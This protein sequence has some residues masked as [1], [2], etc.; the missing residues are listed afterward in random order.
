MEAADASGFDLPQTANKIVSFENISAPDKYSAMTMAR[1]RLLWLHDI[2]GLFRHRSQIDM[3]N[4]VL[5]YSESNR[6]FTKLKSN[7]NH[8]HLI[9]DSR[10]EKANKRLN[11]MISDLRI[12]DGPDG[13]RFFRVIEFHGLSTRSFSNENQ[14]INLW[15]ALETITSSHDGSSSIVDSVTREALPILSLNYFHRIFKY[16]TFDI[17]RWNRRRLS[18]ALAKC[19]FPEHYN[20]VQKVFCLVVAEENDPVK[21]ELLADMDDFELLRFRIFQLN[22]EMREGGLIREKL[23]AHFRRVNWQIHRIYRERN[24]IIHSSSVTTNTESL[25]VNAHDYFDQI[26]DVTASLCSGLSGFRTYQECYT[27]TQERHDEYLKGLKS[28]ERVKTADATRILW[29]PKAILTKE[30]SFRLPQDL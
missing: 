4:D 9:S 28:I 13:Q 24:L 2:Y 6:V 17:L 18:D 10:P 22:K 20:L 5:V 7:H 11:S 25:I 8:M 30:G 26:F 19:E 12:P 16:L 21:E 15:T 14:L 1:T 29:Q 27:Y 23:A 3:S